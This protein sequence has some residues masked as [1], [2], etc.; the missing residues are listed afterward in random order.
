MLI[1]TIAPAGL[2]AALVDL[3]GTLV[4]TVGDFEVALRLALGD[5]GLPTVGRAFISRTVGKGTE[6]LLARTLAEVGAPAERFEAL[7]ARKRHAVHDDVRAR[8]P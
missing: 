8:I 3:D 7:H 2:D 4:D 6:H 1:N 5:L